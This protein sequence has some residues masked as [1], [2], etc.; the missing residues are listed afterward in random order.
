MTVATSSAFSPLWWIPILL[1]AVAIGGWWGYRKT[2][3]DLTRKQ[4][5]GLGML[6]GVALALLV[7]VFAG[8]EATLVRFHQRPYRLS[9]LIDGS[10][11]MI[12]SDRNGSRREAV[13]T[14]LEKIP[15]GRID[16]AVLVADS[17]V[18]GSN[19]AALWQSSWIPANYSSATRMMKATASDPPTDG[20]LWVTDGAVEEADR[21]PYPQKSV[22]AIAVGDTLPPPNAYL[23][24][25][26]IP[27]RVIAGKSVSI[28]VPIGAE[29]LAGRSGSLELKMS[30]GTTTVRNLTL[31]VDGARDTVTLSI[32]A[33]AP[34]WR[35]LMITLTV[36]GDSLLTD[37]Q[38]IVPIYVRVAQLPVTIVYGNLHPD[39]AAIRRALEADSGFLVTAIPEVQAN[40]PPSSGIL[41]LMHSPREGMPSGNVVAKWAANFDRGMLWLP[42]SAGWSPNLA[43][44]FANSDLRY[45]GA[46]EVKSVVP[47]PT[48][49]RLLSGSSIEPDWGRLPPVA[50]KRNAFSAASNVAATI[51]GTDP[52]VILQSGNVNRAAVFVW[53]LW[54]WQQAP[55]ESGR[56]S[57]VDRF[58][59]SLAEWL[60]ADRSKTF[61]SV[62]DRHYSVGVPGSLEAIWFAPTGEPI[63]GAVVA[64]ETGKEKI[65]LEERDPGRYAAKWQ[66]KQAGEQSLLFRGTTTDNQIAVD[67]LHIA[68]D[69]F[70]YEH[71]NAIAFPK[72]LAESS[73]TGGGLVPPDR[74]PNLL[75]SLHQVSVQDRQEFPIK[76][77]H[78]IYSLILLL[79][80]LSVE[81]F[82]RSR[83]GLL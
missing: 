62:P 59:R 77:W 23:G 11:S 66:P 80:L 28:T 50:G 31:P 5:I 52:A 33:S 19:P 41:F 13:R 9:V 82:W 74:I 14:I 37:N 39:I 51:E 67:T 44:Q 30:G 55:I 70:S 8:F 12:L 71:Q 26:D 68:V 17:I 18:Y 57:A 58:W 20:V 21:I 60:A 63:T 35:T 46:G 34:G 83:I 27:L 64:M 1:I 75:D 7:L 69:R 38:L 10:E 15:S 76:L 54:R 24:D 53:D 73:Q 56:P 42:G 47:I 4:R 61:R 81:W 2:T 29:G 25:P 45:R 36:P 65:L 43:K 78:S 48:R 6:R 40:Q 3:P 72:R 22:W 49:E 79:L 16:R 32:K